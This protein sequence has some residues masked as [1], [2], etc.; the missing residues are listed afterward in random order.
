MRV[1]KH[2]FTLRVANTKQAVLLEVTGEICDRE[3][4]RGK[5]RTEMKGFR[6]IGTFMEYTFK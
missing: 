5:M 6:H 4:E 1:E 2:F 3:R